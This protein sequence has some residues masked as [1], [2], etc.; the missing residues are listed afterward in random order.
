M[1]R[2]PRNCFD[3]HYYHI[4]VQGYEKQHIFDEDSLKERYLCLLL[5]ESNNYNVSI[6][7]YCIMGNHAHVLLYINDAYS[8]GKYMQKV[9]STYARLYNA[10]KN[11]VG[12]VFRDRYKSQPI[13]KRTYLY[14]TITYIHH[15]PVAAN[16]V[17]KMQDYE[18]SSYKDFLKGT[19]IINRSMLDKLSLDYDNYLV[20]FNEIHKSFGEGIEYESDQLISSTVET[21]AIL[22]DIV[23]KINIHIDEM[24][25]YRVKY[26]LA[27]Y[28]LNKNVK[29]TV[30]AKALKMAYRTVRDI[31]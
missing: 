18:Y 15:N 7:S 31:L 24:R 26:F 9:N 28:L 2:L 6:L 25:D 13:F 5:S 1:P 30:I 17:S 12:Y 22:N 10:I 11:R 3:T 19:G 16:M 4:V 27:K 14:N 29:V 20:A 23:Y 21:N 8:M